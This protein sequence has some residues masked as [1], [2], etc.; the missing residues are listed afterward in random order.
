MLSIDDRSAAASSHRS[1]P[2]RATTTSP[3]ARSARAAT[4][5]GSDAGGHATRIRSE[6]RRRRRKTSRSAGD[7]S[8]SHRLPSSAPAGSRLTHPAAN[9]A[10][11]HGDAAVIERDQPIVDADPSGDDVGRAGRAVRTEAAVKPRPCDVEVDDGHPAALAGDG[12]RKPDDGVRRGVLVAGARDG[13]GRG[14]RQIDG[15]DARTHLADALPRVR[16][17]AAER[18]EN[19]HAQ[20]PAELARRAGTSASGPGGQDEEHDRDECARDRGEDGVAHDVL[21]LGARRRGGADQPER[22]P[23]RSR[24]ACRWPATA[25]RACR[26]A[27]ASRPARRP[28]PSG[29]CDVVATSWR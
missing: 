27:P 14:P 1:D 9:G 21:V 4:A 29:G 19:G 8:M 3:S 5:S 24:C 15:G 10:S 11:G 7:D 13:D 23:S 28:G 12:E 16:H 6:S 18:A 17:R 2:S 22:R 20:R 26:T 25:A